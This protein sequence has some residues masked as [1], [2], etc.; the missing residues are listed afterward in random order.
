LA[1]LLLDRK[2]P[3]TLVLH[4]SDKAWEWQQRGARTEVADVHDTEALHAVFRQGQ[5]L[6]LLNP[7]AAPATDTAREERKSVASI[8]A[9]LNGSGLRK[10][11]AES[12]YG[13]QPGGSV[14]DLG[15]LYELEQ[16]LAAQPIPASLI[17][18]AYYFSNW[19]TALASARKD[20]QV[21]S[22]FP[23][24]FAL[25]MVAPRD[26]AQLAARL[27]TEPLGHTG[28]HYIEGPAR[29][30]AAD[31]AAAFAAALH[32][33]VAVDAVARPQ[34]A[35]TL[36]Q[37]GFSPAAADSLAAM[38]G[39]TLDERYAQPQNPVRGTTTLTQYIKDLVK[40]TP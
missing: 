29:Y 8:L 34:W 31:V 1:Q 16:G 40:A 18:A 4:S 27:L 33:P 39:V 35:D 17:R 24:D 23:A 5:R 19:D 28:L 13:A 30:S 2:E 10:I 15:V 7:P 20:G 11:V 6:F 3:V 32:R 22:L 37:L 14:G 26:I 38:T 25:P 12:T 36:L 9:A 21:M